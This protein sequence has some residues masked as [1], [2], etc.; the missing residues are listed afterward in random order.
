M[1]EMIVIGALYVGSLAAFRLLGGFH[2]ASE[3]VRGWG[4]AQ[5]R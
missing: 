5:T 2:T 1:L 3:V 4:A